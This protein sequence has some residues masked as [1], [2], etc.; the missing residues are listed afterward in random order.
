MAHRLIETER[1]AGPAA[2]F[3]TSED[4]AGLAEAIV[5]VASDPELRAGL[6]RAGLSRV[7]DRTWERSEAEL[8]RAYEAL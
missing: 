3:P 4:A 6:A 2:V 5:R 8:V 1:T 7:R